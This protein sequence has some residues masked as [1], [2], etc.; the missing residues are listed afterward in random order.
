MLFLVKAKISPN[1]HNCISVPLIQWLQHARITLHHLSNL[2]VLLEV[3]T[4]LLMLKD[5]NVNAFL[6]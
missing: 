1:F 5:I 4:Q 6:P 3:Y 2:N